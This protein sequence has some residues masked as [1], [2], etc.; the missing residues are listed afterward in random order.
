MIL[1]SRY[2]GDVARSRRAF[3]AFT[4][5]FSLSVLYFNLVLLGATVGYRAIEGWGWMDCAYMAVTTA[6]S[7]GFSEV[8]PLSTAGRVFTMIVLAF[9]LVGLG[10]LWAMVTAFLVELDLADYFRRRSM[11]NRIDHLSGHYIVCG[12]GRVGRVIFGEMTAAG[13][14]VVLVDRNH[15]RIEQMRER[16]P[17]ILTVE[18][19]ATLDHI[20]QIA[21]ITRARGLAAALASDADNL[22]VCLTARSLNA[23]LEIACRAN[24]GE[25]IPKMAQ[26]G[27]RHVV[28]PNVTGGVRMAASLLRP[29][30]VSFLDAST[31]TSEFE[32][33]LEELPVPSASHLVGKTLA[34]ARI[35]QETGLIVLALRS[36]AGGESVFNP[37]GDAKLCAGDV[38]IVLGQ[39]AQIDRLRGFAG[40]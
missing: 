16:F 6:T 12:A 36:H 3:R 5:R 21:G 29:S 4:Q 20:L 22:F 2:T 14:T 24:D 15:E 40:V 10:F 34:Q 1:Q 37:G 30:V 11:Q 33:R 26:A 23:D 19:D 9:S 8:H 39:E 38:M 35:P 17:N 7:V 18:G 32:L 25:S 28:S 27:A 13:Q 31:S